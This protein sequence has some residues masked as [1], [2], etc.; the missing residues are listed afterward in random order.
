LQKAAGGLRINEEKSTSAQGISA[1]VVRASRRKA[2]QKGLPADTKVSL[3][4]FLKNRVNLCKSVSEENS[5]NPF[6]AKATKGRRRLKLFGI[7]NDGNDENSGIQRQRG[8]KNHS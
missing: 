7:I 2:S 5:V 3:I 1:Q 6:F 4:I 8:Q